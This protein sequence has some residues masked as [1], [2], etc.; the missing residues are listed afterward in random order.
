MQTARLA[1][2]SALCLTLVPLSACHK[3]K[4]KGSATTASTLSDPNALQSFDGQVGRVSTN[5]HPADCAGNIPAVPPVR[6]VAGCDTVGVVQPS[7]GLCFVDP[8][9]APQWTNEPPSSGPEY[10]VPEFGYYTHAT[11]VPRGNWVR[12]LAHG[13]VVILYNCPAGC[14]TDVANIDRMIRNDL[15]GTPTIFTPDPLL[16]TPTRFAA[17]AWNYLYAF[18]PVDLV[19]LKCFIN[20]HVSHGQVD[21]IAP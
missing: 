18:D 15:A 12:S 8:R 17:V 19:S 13:F 7:E 11:P 16:R 5:P 21:H 10:G 3:K 9:V 14:A 6:T 4:A 2:L 1:A 20:Q